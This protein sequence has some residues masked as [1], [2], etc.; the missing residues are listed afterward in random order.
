MEGKQNTTQKGLPQF[1]HYFVLHQIQGV[2]LTLHPKVANLL[3]SSFI[4]LPQ[5]PLKLLA[6]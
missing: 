1:F 4:V 3:Y 5:A 2:K 6:V